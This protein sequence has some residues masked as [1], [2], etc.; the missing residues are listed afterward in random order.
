[1]SLEQFSALLMELGKSLGLELTPDEHDSCLI[2]SPDGLKI[3]MEMDP[4]EE[5]FLICTEVSKV[6]LGRFRED[7]FREA[8]KYNGSP[9]PRIGDLCLQRKNR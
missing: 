1:M 4:H 6:P 9:L 8:L 7:V 2:P 5:N 3:Q